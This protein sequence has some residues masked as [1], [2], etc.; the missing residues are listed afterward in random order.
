MDNKLCYRCQQTLPVTDFHKNKRRPDG[1]A[2]SCKECHKAECR[3]HRARHKVKVYLRELANKDK[4]KLEVFSHYCDG[5]IACKC[6]YNDLRALT[7][8]HIDGGGNE[9][10]KLIKKRCGTDFY[11]WV[12]KNNYPSGIQVLCMNCQ[13]VKRHENNEMNRHHKKF[14]AP[15]GEP[16]P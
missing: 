16:G 1:L 12:K 13:F 11:R 15:V 10:R 9:H 4:V 8:D 3:E 14:K 2:S 6:G 5:P 7:L